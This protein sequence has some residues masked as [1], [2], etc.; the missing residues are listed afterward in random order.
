MYK[1]FRRFVV[2]GVFAG[3]AFTASAAVPAVEKLLPDDT[4]VMVTTPDFLKARD[5]YHSAPQSQLWNDPAMKPFKD[6][7]IAKLN[8][9]FVQP[10]EKDLGIKFEDYT[11]LA[12]GQIALAV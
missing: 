5:I 2:L 8:Q 4:L 11:N 7:F 9:N 10:L 6:N 1:N 12:Q 3:I